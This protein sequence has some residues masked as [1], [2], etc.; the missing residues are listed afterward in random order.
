MRVVTCVP[1]LPAC[2]SVFLPPVF[3]PAA[4]V[5]FPRGS[6]CLALIFVHYA[7][8]VCIALTT[9]I[10]PIDTA[11]NGFFRLHGGAIMTL[12]T[13]RCSYNTTP[14]EI[15]PCQVQHQR[16]ARPPEKMPPSYGPYVTR[17]NPALL[18]LVVPFITCYY[19]GLRSSG[20]GPVDICLSSCLSFCFHLNGFQ[21]VSGEARGNYPTLTLRTPALI[22]CDTVV[23]WAICNP[24]QA[25]PPYRDFPQK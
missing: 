4:G 1:V 11:P 12:R 18:H 10:N 2:C 24:A 17:L 16:R 3:P 23:P 9:R 21:T 22:F 14:T 19:T 8:S 20:T 5:C 7:N 13:S 25:L 6:S 15:R